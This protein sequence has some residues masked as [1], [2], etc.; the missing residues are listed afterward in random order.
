MPRRIENHH[1]VSQKLRNLGY[2]EHQ[3]IRLYGKEFH[4]VSNPVPEGS[5][6]VVEGIERASGAQRKIR[7]PLPVVCMV[8]EQVFVRETELVAA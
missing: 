3:C 6:F 5:G 7:I 8:R 4:L 2:A 1:V